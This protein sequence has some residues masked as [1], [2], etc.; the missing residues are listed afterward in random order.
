LLAA[1]SNP[2]TIAGF[3][4]G[5]IEIS[6]PQEAV[7]GCTSVSVL[8]AAW[9]GVLGRLLSLPRWRAIYL[10]AGNWTD[11]VIGLALPG[12]AVLAVWPLLHS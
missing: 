7:V 11:V 1:V 3:L 6:N 5:R 10:Q 2:V 9:F 4:I 8:A 12:C